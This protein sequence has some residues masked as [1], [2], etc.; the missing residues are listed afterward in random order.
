MKFAERL[1]WTTYL[2]AKK[3]E[4]VRLGRL[5][6]AALD[7]D[8]T[9][10]FEMDLKP[11]VRESRGLRLSRNLYA[12]HVLYVLRPSTSGSRP[13]IPT[14]CSWSFRPF[15]VYNDDGFKT[16]KLNLGLLW[17]RFI[18]GIVLSENQEL[19]LKFEPENL[20]INGGDARTLWSCYKLLFSVQKTKN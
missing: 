10:P 7:G 20:W 19:Q 17:E 14:P 3:V 11:G 6:N 5:K 12:K 9:I 16:Y 8:I 18:K 15:D 13:L 4:R 2:K 1:S